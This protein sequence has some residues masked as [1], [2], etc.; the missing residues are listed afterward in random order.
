MMIGWRSFPYHSRVITRLKLGGE[1]HLI[2]ALRHDHGQDA[3]PKHTHL[4]VEN[5]LAMKKNGV[6]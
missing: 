4:E 3:L 1:G 5:V 6:S 2:V